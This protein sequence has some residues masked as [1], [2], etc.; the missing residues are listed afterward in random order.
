MFDLSMAKATIKTVKGHQYYVFPTAPP[1]HANQN[2]RPSTYA[3][4]NL[5]TTYNGKGSNASAKLIPEVHDAANAMMT[6]LIRYGE[7]I[8]D[9]SM[10]NAVIQSGYRPDDASQGWNY[11]RIIKATIRAKPEIFGTLEFPSSLEA[12]AQSVL[13]RRGDPR[14]TAFQQHLAAAEGWNANLAGTLFRIV[15]GVYAPRG[16]NPHA[17]GLV[18]DL[19]FPIFDGS[20]ER[21]LGADTNWNA[22]ALRSAAGMWLNTYS[23]QFG[24]DSYDTGKEI[25]HME[26]RN[27]KEGPGS[28]DAI[29]LLNCCQPALE[30]VDDLLHVS[31]QAIRDALRRIPL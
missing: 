7:K 21:N 9:W 6:A 8:N 11:L 13:G 14:R 3:D 17:T 25:W 10:R 2:A 29:K 20:H 5:L 22:T 27:P 12:E 26:W 23:M 19:D 18:F 30:L 24:F 15:D 31:D 1:T 16:S 4:S 28:P